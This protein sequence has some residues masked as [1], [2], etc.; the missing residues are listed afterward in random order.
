M[1]INE[2]A[3]GQWPSIL[4]A[5]A[6]LSADQLTDKHQPCPLCGG[7]DRYR[8]DDQDGNG[9]WFCNKCGGKNHTG[10]AG[11]GMDM[12]MRKNN[13]DF[14]TAASAIENFLG[15]KPQR[16]E[17]PTKGA[18]LVS[19]YSENFI[20]C[21]FPGKKIRPLWWDG[22]KWAWKAPPAPRP[23]LNLAK[24][25]STSCS[26][27]ITEGEKACDAATKL[28]PLA[29]ATTWPSGCKAINKCDFTP[30]KGRKVALWP[31]NDD[32]GREAMQKVA[33]KLLKLGVAEVRV[34][35][36][37]ADAS[38][39]WDLADS[40]FTEDE[41]RLY[42]LNNSTIYTLPEVDDEP[43]LHIEEEEDDDDESTAIDYF[44]CLGH[45]RGT[46]H[47]LPHKGGQVIALP[48]ASHT[49]LNL[50]NLAPLGYWMSAFPK[51]SSADWDKAADELMSQSFRVGIFDPQMVRG[52]GAWYDRQRVIMHLGNRLDVIRKD[53]ETE[54]LSI[55]NPPDTIYFYEKAKTLTGPSDECLD[56]ET[57]LQLI[58]LAKK[59]KWDD[60]IYAQ[61]LLGWIVLAPVCGALDW[62]PHIW[63]TGGAGTGK[64]TILKYFMRPLLAGIFQ[65]ATGGTTEA[66]L[67]GTLKSDAIPVVFDEF[68]QNE[69][70]DKQ[71]VQNVLSL[72][73]IASSEGGKIYKGTTSGGANSFEI[74]SMFCVSSIN[75]NLIQKADIDRFCVLC[76]H[77][78]AA[79]EEKEDWFEFESQILSLCTEDNGRRLIARTLKNIPAIRENAKTFSTAL[80]RK[81]GARYGDQHGYLLAGWYSLM[82]SGGDVVTL[83]FAL[84][85]VDG[86]AWPE[87]ASADPMEADEV[88]CLNFI[89]DSLV[90]VD[91]KKISIR[92]L[93]G[94][95]RRGVI[96]CTPMK[97]GSESPEIVLARYGIKIHEG[98]L[99]I[100]NS[101]K[102][103][104]SLLKETQWS[105]NA[106]RQSLRRIDGAVVPQSPIRF[107]SMGLSRGTLIPCSAFE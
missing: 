60:P 70:R 24:I 94:M 100:A 82:A 87:A 106:Y 44:S 28:F 45:D 8:F 6:G 80:A 84:A 37:P 67:R 85:L 104:Q 38:E 42:L 23:L 98:M 29:V 18:E 88:K 15:V 55:H 52:R 72:A 86:I 79:G 62:R 1:K 93:V 61:F 81:R 35:E 102:N 27:I 47:Y 25:L 91:T 34:V 22:G 68:E 107:P 65:S 2:I 73:R 89:L 9:S 95:A 105:G 63:I 78:P 48:A 103:L 14:K 7:T 51:G 69:A 26:V 32:A 76:L 50:L 71:I 12:L 31:D 3:Q 4:G 40:E 16:P 53:A 90:A 49:K 101:Q 21:R 17:P 57:C 66:G 36:P 59:F 54:H 39:G 56:N 77:K 13:W 83:D 33:D 46:Y 20:V 43:L 10:G 97:D 75:V 74:R 11:N 96:T 30:L 64:T 41:A 58:Q 19:H 5:L 99:A 92:E